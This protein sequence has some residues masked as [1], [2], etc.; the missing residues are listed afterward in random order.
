M[1]ICQCI[2]LCIYIEVHYDAVTDIYKLLHIKTYT[3]ILHLVNGSNTEQLLILLQR[4]N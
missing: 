4:K 3:D 2:Y 1:F